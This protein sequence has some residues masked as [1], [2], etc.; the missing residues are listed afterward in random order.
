M[1][2]Q[3]RPNRKPC[4]AFQPTG[5]LEERSGYSASVELSSESQR[6]IR[7]IPCEDEVSGAG[8]QGLFRLLNEANRRVV[9]CPSVRT[10]C[11][12]VDS[13]E[14]GIGPSDDA[15]NRSFD[16]YFRH[17]RRRLQGWLR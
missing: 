13:T 8:L 10:E 3:I 2:V 7:Q 15:A 14:V 17:C 9:L 1:P 5:S 16:L 12:V 11:P 6:L 4:C